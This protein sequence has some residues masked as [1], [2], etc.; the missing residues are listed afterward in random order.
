MSNNLSLN[1]KYGD[2]QCMQT[3]L[4]IECACV[5]VSKIKTHVNYENTHKLKKLNE[6][7]WL[8]NKTNLK[9]KKKK[10][11]SMLTSNVDVLDDVEHVVLID[12]ALLL[13]VQDVINGALEPMVIG[14][15]RARQLPAR[16]H[17]DKQTQT[18]VSEN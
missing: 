9:R 1:N 8:L 13:G 2:N 6:F 11:R 17:R 3:L 7:I 4:R 5:Y 16:A 10:K 14:R 12:L 15:L 18:I